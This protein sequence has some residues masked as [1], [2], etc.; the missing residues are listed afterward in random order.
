VLSALLATV[1]F[2]VYFGM[3]VMRANERIRLLLLDRIKP[4]LSDTSNIE[5]VSM[6]LNSLHLKGIKLSPKDHSFSIEIDDVR[7]GYRL[8]NLVVYGF[9]PHKMTHQLVVDHPVISI[10][11]PVFNTVTSLD[12]TGNIDFQNW[13]QEF[14]S[15]QRITVLNAEINMVD[16]MSHSVRM[17]HSLNG[18]FESNPVDSAVVRLAGNLFESQEENLILRGAINLLKARPVRMTAL[19]EEFNPVSGLPFLIPDFIEVTQGKVK[20]E[21]YFNPKEKATGFLDISDAQLAFRNAELHF[22]DVNL[23][24]QFKGTDLEI[25]GT[26]RRFNDSPLA[27]KGSILEILRPRLNIRVN[28]Q[29]MDVQA[30]FQR[31]IP[32]SRLP[33]HGNVNLDLHATGA[34]NNPLVRGSVKSSNLNVYRL[35]IQRFQAT[36]GLRDSVITVF[37]QGANRDNFQL[38]LQGLIDFSDSTEATSLTMNMKGDLSSILP[39]WSR[40]RVQ[41]INGNLNT[42]IDGKLRSL[43]GSIQGRLSLASVDG[44]SLRLYPDLLYQNKRLE[45]QIQS[46]GNSFIAGRIQSPFYDTVEWNLIADGIQNLIHPFLGPSLQ[47]STDHLRLSAQF[48]GSPETWKFF[49]YGSFSEN[50]A[51]NHFQLNVF[52]MSVKKSNTF[53]LEGEY[54]GQDSSKIPLDAELTWFDDKIQLK[55]FN[56]GDYLSASGQ[57][58][59]MKDGDISGQFKLQTVDLEKFHGPFP[60]VRPFSGQ[61]QGSG[62]IKGARSAYNMDL[63]INLKN[64]RFHDIGLYQGE[65]DYK[66][67]DAKFSSCGFHIARNDSLLMKG[68]IQ[69]SGLDSLVGHLFSNQVDWGFFLGSLMGKSPIQGKG[70][71]AL[72]I[73]GH[74][75][76]PEIQGSLNLL[77]GAFS[78]IHFQ[79]FLTEFQHTFENSTLGGGLLHLK[80]CEIERADGLKMT[81]QGNIP[82]G[83]AEDVDLSIH[84]KGNILGLLPELSS[85]FK[86]GSGSGEA[87]LRWGGRPGEWAL[88]DSYIHFDDAKLELNTF[89]KK[90]KKIRGDFVLRTNDRFLEIRNFEGEINGGRFRLTNRYTEDDMNHY[91]PLMIDKLKI[92]LG[93]LQLLAPGKGIRVNL[94]GLMEKGDQGWIAFRGL[95][96]DTTLVIAGPGEHPLVRGTLLLNN[97]RLTYPLLKLGN[98]DGGQD[99]LIPL[100]QKIYWDL[101]VRPV[102]DVY[103]V[104]TIESPLGNVYTDLQ[105]KDGVGGL[106]IQG[107]INERS[108]R[109]SGNL[110][111]TEGSIDALDHYFRVDRIVF[112]YPLGASDPL[113]SGRAYTTV[114]DSMGIPSTIWMTLQSTDENTGIEKSGG[115]WKKIHFRFSSDNPN[116]GRT[117]A[118]LM[119]A[120]GYSSSDMK[121]RAYDALGMRV[122]NLVFRPIFRPLERGLRRHLGF[123]VVRLTSRLSRNLVEMQTINPNAIDPRLLLRSTRLTLGKYLFPG[124]FVTYSGQVHKGVGFQYQTHGLGFRHALILEYTIQPDLFLEMEYTYDSKLLW[125]RRE[126]KR[127]WIRHVFPF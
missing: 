13:M 23:R 90:I 22:T 100:L 27:L 17:A 111:S 7:L 65:F 74:Y 44:D 52:P 96:S 4:Y 53:L 75:S 18:W 58:P 59:L 97:V 62:K 42:Q 72:D 117:E 31:L 57:F 121:E 10:L 28:S 119:A 70:R 19:I 46:G 125:D 122:D 116:I 86:K 106:R 8:W 99:P 15:V 14:E 98:S 30:F 35:P 82:Y 2:G 38:D 105:L 104:R 123:D 101:D 93:V 63:N 95:N 3:R 29:N 32:D 118:D 94:P 91:V 81:A 40:K 102:K 50:L 48:E 37:G 84:A 24:G 78:G 103:Y 120:L 68:D 5:S 34:M 69:T 88:G 92:H 80:T 73:K 33:I 115:P 77:D 6:S 20:G 87:N 67:E 47:S 61:I 66:R 21:I 79:K 76:S 127:I 56:A 55:T 25:Q 107:I 51:V 49:T 41:G 83:M 112:D 89:V 26:V 1:I 60:M 36:L 109:V 114:I 110:E 39:E 43:N 108:L 113:I 54:T 85:T 45:I 16:S 71:I 126:D 64:G 9:V 12:S 11:N 124:M